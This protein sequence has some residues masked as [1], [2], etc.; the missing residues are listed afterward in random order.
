MLFPSC[1]HP[2]AANGVIGLVQAR[3]TVSVSVL[4]CLSGVLPSVSLGQTREFSGLVTDSAGVPV[5]AA[6][7][8]V[9]GTAIRTRTNEQGEF[10]LQGIQAGVAEIRVRRLGFSATTQHLRVNAN[11]SAEDVRVVLGAVPTSVAPVVVQAARVEY[12]GRLAG[13]Y[14]RLHRRSNGSFITREQLD[15][16]ENKSLSQML[17]SMPSV[18]PVRGGAVRMRGMRCRPLVWL[19]GVPMPAGE[20]DLDAFPVSTLQGVEVYLGT[21]NAPAAYSP[22]PGTSSCGSV[23]LWSRGRDTERPDVARLRMD[24]EELAASHAI[25]THEQ[26]DTPAQLEQRTLNVKYPLDLAASQT[27]GSAVAEFVVS[28]TG[29]IEEGSMDIVSATHSLFARSALEALA[30]A[31]FSPAIKGGIPVRQLVQQPFTFSYG[32]DPAPPSARR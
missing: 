17:S 6:I 1:G 2:G 21:S 13:Y 29:E 16:N 31:H 7:V 19:D 23:L 28:E 14:E 25:Y 20:V 32:A 12:T 24:L 30:G 3:N 27:S 15:K 11:E 4:L 10:H 8:E 9:P 22:P 5:V 26:V 18:R